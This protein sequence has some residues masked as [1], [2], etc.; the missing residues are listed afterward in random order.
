[1]NIVHIVKDRRRG[2]RGKTHF[3][4]RGHKATVCGIQRRFTTPSFGIPT[5]QVCKGNQVSG[6]NGTH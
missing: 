1:M 6:N 5:C 2:G 3:I 4:I